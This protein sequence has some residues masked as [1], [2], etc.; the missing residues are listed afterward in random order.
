MY[1]VS[2]NFSSMYKIFNFSTKKFLFHEKKYD[3]LSLKIWLISLKY[4]LGIIGLHYE[5]TNRFC[6]EVARSW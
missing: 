4:L 5:G 1:L 3:C 6:S 2:I